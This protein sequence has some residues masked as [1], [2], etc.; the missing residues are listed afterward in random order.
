MR[1]HPHFQVV[2]V[3][4]EAVK[5]TIMFYLL[6]EQT[7]KHGVV[8]SIASKCTFSEKTIQTCII[9]KHSKTT[10]QHLTK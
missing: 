2:K 8:G 10:L 5:P 9:Q 6:E 7:F 4:C 1:K 3:D